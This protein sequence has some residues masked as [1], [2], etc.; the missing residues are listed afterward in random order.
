MSASVMR[1]AAGEILFTK[2]AK[3]RLQDC[4]GVL[5]AR[6][7]SSPSP[8]G[9]QPMADRETLRNRVSPLDLYKFTPRTNC[10]ECGQNTCLAFATQV[11]AGQ[12]DI[13]ACP[14]LDEQQVQTLRDRLKEQLRSGIGVSRESFEK[15]MEFLY[16]EVKKCDFRVTAES[17]GAEIEE[18]A[19]RSALIL[20][21]F[22][23][24][25]LV[26][27][28]DIKNL[29]GCELSSWEKI[30][31]FNYVIGGATEPSGIW[32]GMESLPNSVSKVKSL[33]A[34][35]EEPLSRL[36]SGK[37]H[38]FSQAIV[39]W[40][41][42]VS[43][44]DHGVDFAAEFPVFPKLAIRVLFWDEIKDE[45]YACQVKFLFDSRVLQVLDL[46]SLIFACEQITDRLSA[47]LK[48]G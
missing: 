25:I 15:T 24:L 22:S 30:F 33:K 12:E 31:I 35:C 21:Y 10:G 23:D 39:P 16:E 14:Y 13:D 44:K 47:R 34:H 41:R 45:G 1:T 20:P 28:F 29:S 2:Q 7:E 17:L 19:D 3:K 8:E 26:T 4:V 32:V 37:V 5:Q 43:L 36:L 38:L 40:G 27:R 48:S 9:M 18:S 6:P 46:E 11:I 42:E